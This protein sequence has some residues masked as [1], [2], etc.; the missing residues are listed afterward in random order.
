METRATSNTLLAIFDH[1]GVLSDAEKGQIQAHIIP[2]IENSRG[3]VVG[4]LH[5]AQFQ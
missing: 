3:L 2:P 1:L 4:N 5:P